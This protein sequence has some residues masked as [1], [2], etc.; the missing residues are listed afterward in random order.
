MANY[1]SSGN[2]E[3]I[4]FGRREVFL[5]ALN[6]S[7]LQPEEE[8]VQGICRK[9]FQA[10]LP[11]SSTEHALLDAVRLVEESPISEIQFSGFIDEIRK[12]EENQSPVPVVIAFDLTYKDHNN[13]VLS[14][15]A[16]ALQGGLPVI[17]TKSC[18]SGIYGNNQKDRTLVIDRALALKANYDIYDSEGWL[19]FLPKKM[20]LERLDIDKSKCHPVEWKQVF[21]LKREPATLGNF[22]QLFE[23][24]QTHSKLID[25]V[26]HGRIGSPCG[27]SKEEYHQFIAWANQAKTEGLLLMSCLSGGESSLLHLDNEGESQRVQFPVLI[28]S[29]GDFIIYQ[30]LDPVT[31]STEFASK[32]FNLWSM[33]AGRT[34]SKLRA[35]LRNEGSKQISQ[36]PVV[37][38]LQ[39]LFPS[40]KAVPQGFRAV[41]ETRGTKSLTYLDAVAHQVKN[42]PI[43]LES[44][45]FI[46]L[47]APFI[48]APIQC[49]ILGPS[50]V[51]MIPGQAHHI[52]KR[53]EV[54]VSAQEWIEGLFMRDR[55]VMVNKGLFIGTLQCSEGILEEVFVDLRNGSFGF[56]KE[57]QYFYRL[58]HTE[59][60]ELLHPLEF[61]LA[62]QTLFNDTTPSKKALRSQTSGL[63]NQDE[64][65]HFFNDCF[66]VLLKVPLNVDLLNEIELDRWIALEKITNDELIAL[67]SYLIRFYPFKAVGF[68]DAAM[69]F[70][71]ER[72]R[73]LNRSLFQEAVSSGERVLIRYFLDKEG[74]PYLAPPGTEPP[75]VLALLSKEDLID[76]FLEIEGL[77]IDIK[78]LSDV[79]AYL[80]IDNLEVLRK[81]DQRFPN[82][83]WNDF[84]K[85]KGEWENVLVP[86]ILKGNREKITFLLTHNVNPN[87]WLGSFSPLGE[88]IKRGDADLIEQLLYYKANPYILT[89]GSS[90]GLTEAIRLGS[91]QWVKRMLE[92]PDEDQDEDFK[93]YCFE[94]A[95]QTGNETMIRLIGTISPQFSS[96]YSWDRFNEGEANPLF[97]RLVISENWELISEIKEKY[98]KDSLHFQEA[99]FAAV[100]ALRPEAMLEHQD[101]LGRFSNPYE[102]IEGKQAVILSV[103]RN[104]PPEVLAAIL[105]SPL[106]EV[107]GKN[108]K[109]L[110]LVQAIY[111][112]DEAKIRQILA[113]HPEVPADF[114]W[115]NTSGLFEKLLKNKNWDFIAELKK[116]LSLDSETFEE[117]LFR[118][119]MKVCPEK[120]FD[121]RNLFERKH[122]L[123]LLVFRS[124]GLTSEEK[125]SFFRMCLDEGLSPDSIRVEKADLFT[126]FD[127]KLPLVFDLILEGREN[128]L[129]YL[130]S[131][132][133]DLSVTY[134]GL[135]PMDCAAELDRGLMQ[136]MLREYLSD[137]P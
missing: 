64:V 44:S 127:R 17:T 16:Q 112:G 66:P 22:K 6:A 43:N 88:A 63:I 27:L 109:L 74:D 79:K 120:F 89:I 130:L 78:D 129:S 15:V 106:S 35:F 5:Q 69:L 7:H 61:A 47:S 123:L 26:G 76:P 108:I 102:S 128:E 93:R 18:F 92:I 85:H 36:S 116:T 91:V 59:N 98:A 80:R 126:P 3:P 60:A 133:P 81:V 90:S 13:A 97:S 51:S 111:S 42:K 38:Y 119:I 84:S 94:E 65:R 105:N 12:L 33:P 118:N 45:F 55:G 136:E 100:K 4:S 37:N 34:L 11:A 132:N 113:I 48:E 25:V 41:A 70:P 23:Q 68:I 75:L 8:R 73:A 124:G 101:L 83:N 122:A 46:E 54:G 96:D 95:I 24:K 72:I 86:E 28:R 30:G 29:V 104:H 107:K 52:L 125:A 2:F 32:L 9:Y 114:Q 50:F 134:G 71:H 62:A 31:E 39:V 10:L 131:K 67:A 40:S 110:M 57:G 135:S 19:I 53:L 77:K 115:R 137:S 20:G 49:G 87:A 82:L 117:I 121:L 21:S 56:K 14:R 1:I 58:P 103:I 99:L